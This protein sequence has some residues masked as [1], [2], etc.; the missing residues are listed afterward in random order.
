MKRVGREEIQLG[1]KG[2]HGTIC[3]K[4]GYLKHREVRET[5]YYTGQLTQGR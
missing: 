5:D 2:T 4:E 1:I 3:R